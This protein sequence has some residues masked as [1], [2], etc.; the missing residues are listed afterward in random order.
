MLELPNEWERICSESNL[1]DNFNVWYYFFQNL[2]TSRARELISKKVSSIIKNLEKEIKEVLN[3]SEGS[4][5]GET[6]L[7]WYTWV[8]DSSDVSRIEN[9]HIGRI[10]LIFFFSSFISTES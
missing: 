6:D 5:C 9:K 3:A 7:R 2:I 8:E 10:G 4:E 1:P